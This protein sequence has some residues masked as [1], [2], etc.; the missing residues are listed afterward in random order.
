MK[1]GVSFLFGVLDTIKQTLLLTVYLNYICIRNISLH[2]KQIFNIHQTNKYLLVIRFLSCFQAS[3][4]TETHCTT[5]LKRLKYSKKEIQDICLLVEN[6]LRPHTFKMGWTDSAVRRYIVDSGEMMDQLNNLV[7]ADIT[8]KNKNKYDEINK[9]LDDM[10]LRIAEVKEKEELSNLRPPV[11]GDDI[12]KLFNLKPGPSVGII[13]KA[14]YEQRL[15]EGEVT[16][17]EAIELAKNI[18]KK[19]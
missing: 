1:I 17:E 11:S 8:T 2:D 4:G 3:F 14:L 10:E 13:M 19:L 16:K 12:M 5:I 7:R 9:Y 6:H 18:F 15:N